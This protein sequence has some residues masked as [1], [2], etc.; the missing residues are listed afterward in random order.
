MPCSSRKNSKFAHVS[1]EAQYA[2]QNL[3]GD[4]RFFENLR[5]CHGFVQVKLH[6]M[7]KERLGTSLLLHFFFWKLIGFY[8]CER[9]DITARMGMF[10]TLLNLRPPILSLSFS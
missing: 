3:A 7:E 4:N 6:E 9:P 2:H 1:L 8:I 5:L 10:L